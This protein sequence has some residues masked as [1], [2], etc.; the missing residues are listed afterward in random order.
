M[1]IVH[2]HETFPLLPGLRTRAVI[3]TEALAENYAA[4][5]APV[6]AVSPHTYAIAVVKADAYGH[7]I[8]P[9]V[10]TLLEAGCRSFA[11]ACLEE[12]AECPRREQCVTL[13]IW[14]GLD[15]L[16]DQYFQGITLAQLVEQARQAGQ[17]GHC[18]MI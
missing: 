1:N 3:D 5:L 11:V 9:V 10:G 7:G 17:V 2:L 13:P 6:Q 15:E 12:G 14:Q 18:A 8:R 4:L 16:I